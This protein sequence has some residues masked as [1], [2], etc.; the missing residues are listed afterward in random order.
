MSSERPQEDNHTLLG[1][2]SPTLVESDTKSVLGVT[3]QLAKNKV[4][5]ANSLKLFSN[6]GY[7]RVA[8]ECKGTA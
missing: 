8:R 4:Y 1:W 5:D 3:E 2:Q 6:D 7:T